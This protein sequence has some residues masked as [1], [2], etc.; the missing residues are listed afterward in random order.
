MIELNLKTKAV[1][2]TTVQFNS[3]AMIGGVPVGA[4]ESGLFRMCGKSDNGVEIPALIK[5]GMFDLGGGNE[6]RFRFFYFGVDTDGELLLSVFCDGE[7]VTQMPVFRKKGP[8]R[9]KVPISRTYQGRYWQW[10]VE[11]VNG[12]FFSLYRVDALPIIMNS[13]RGR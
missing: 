11:N 8:Q 5:S 4:T 13:G 7:Q 2:Q 1:T 6:S 10:Q 9:I 12:S 3:M